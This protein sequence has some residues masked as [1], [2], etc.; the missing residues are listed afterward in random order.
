MAMMGASTGYYGTIR[1]QLAWRQMWYFFKCPVFS[2]AELTLAFAAK[3]FDEH[4]TLV[5]ERYQESLD[6][7]LGAL[8]AWLG[9]R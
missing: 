4:G 7:Y 6:K 9:A 3:A 1:A 8:A 5:E 2:D